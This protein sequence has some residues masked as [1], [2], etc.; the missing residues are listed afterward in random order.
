MKKTKIFITAQLTWASANSLVDDGGYEAML[1]SAAY[2]YVLYRTT[3][4]WKS[5]YYPPVDT[6]SPCDCKLFLYFL[7]FCTS[8]TFKQHFLFV[9]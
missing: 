1:Y 2:L 6:C 3:W 7:Q 5:N 4:S 9:L 8:L